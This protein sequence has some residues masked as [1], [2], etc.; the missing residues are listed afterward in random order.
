MIKKIFLII[1]LSCSCVY[2]EDA[3]N[4]NTVNSSGDFVREIPKELTSTSGMKFWFLQDTSSK[5][6]HV[7]I[8]FMNCGAAY[9][10]KS[11]A[12]TASLYAQSVF[13]GAGKYS[14]QEFEKQC[15]DNSIGISCLADLDSIKFSLTT[16]EIVL[17]EAIELLNAILVSPIFE[18]KEVLK[19]QN[20]LDVDDVVMQTLLLAEIFK[21]HVYERGA[22]G[23]PED[24]A[25]LTVADLKNYKKRFIVKK[26]AKI[27]IC[28]AVSEQQA[29][30]L[31]D[32]VFS[33]M[34]EGQ[35][36]KD[37][38]AD[39]VPKLSEKVTQCYLEGPQSRIVFALKNKP[40]SSEKRRA[41]MILYNLLGSM[42]LMQNRILTDL[43]TNQGLIYAGG[44]TPADMNHANIV[45]GEL[46][47]DNKKTQ[48]TI[49]SLK[50]VIKE[51]KE[52]GITQQ[53]LDLVKNHMLGMTLV[54]LRTSKAL[55]Q[56]YFQNMLRGFGKDVLRK[57]IE[58][59]NNTK[60][61]DVNAVAK[62]LLDDKNLSVIV[63]GGNA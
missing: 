43:R 53:E 8:A 24:Y 3:K 56:F 41:A 19:I 29:I 21:S 44:V 9:L 4:V 36:A 63:I 61:S 12:G 35:K 28:G 15:H 32:K 45:V 23:T 42:S 49:A 27:F 48:K 14:K 60:L 47:T 54:R 16:S 58:E 40:C 2:A 17:R 26:N 50:T 10:Q 25:K 20:S 52:K 57:I 22:I 1:V 46:L 33:K 18:E 37:T 31:V 39:V 13:C 11:K 30:V 5:L 6:V 55:S 7:N 38:V 51:L 62:E 34:S 59:I